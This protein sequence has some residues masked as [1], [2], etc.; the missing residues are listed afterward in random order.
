MQNIHESNW[1]QR[2]LP[3][4]MLPISTEHSTLNNL[5]MP[6]ILQEYLHSRL[7][8]RPV[9]SPEHMDVFFVCSGCTKKNIHIF[10]WTAE[11]TRNTFCRTCRHLQ[12]SSRWHYELP[13]EKKVP[14]NG[15]VSMRSRAGSW[16]TLSICI[17]LRHNQGAPA[18]VHANAL[19]ILIICQFPL[20]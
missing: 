9:F 16:E 17:T 12:K 7:A 11:I 15:A 3:M 4:I 19:G 8:T 10:V 13:M 1:R 5:D 18:D 20:G 2:Q 14:W 6:R